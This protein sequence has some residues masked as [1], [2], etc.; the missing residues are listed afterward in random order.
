MIK[1]Y[2]MSKES[3]LY[4]KLLLGNILNELGQDFLYSFID[5]RGNFSCMDCGSREDH[6]PDPVSVTE[7]VKITIRIRIQGPKTH[8][9]QSRSGSKALKIT[10]RIRIQ[11]PKIQHTDYAEIYI[12]SK[13]FFSQLRGIIQMKKILR[14]E[15]R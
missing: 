7:I 2:D 6:N 3:N 1:I 12:N 9:A 15:L 8:N 14:L 5:F 10:I 13:F 4:S 11:G